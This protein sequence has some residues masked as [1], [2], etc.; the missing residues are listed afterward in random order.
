[1]VDRTPKAELK[2]IN[3]AKPHPKLEK[4]LKRYEAHKRDKT[5]VTREGLLKSGGNRKGLK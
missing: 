2:S 3:R 5:N 1:M 4:S